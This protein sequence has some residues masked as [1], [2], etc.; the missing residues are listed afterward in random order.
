MVDEKDL[1]AKVMGIEDYR[2]QNLPMPNG[3]KIPKR[4]RRSSSGG[5]CRDC[6]HDTLVGHEDGHGMW[7]YTCTYCVTHQNQNNVPCPR[8][9]CKAHERIGGTVSSLSEKKVDEITSNPFR[10][11]VMTFRCLRCSQ[12]WFN[13]EYEQYLLTKVVKSVSNSSPLYKP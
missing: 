2:K 11:E 8:C 7:H 4:A 3:I 1:Y 5:H 13:P 6:G 12:E 10:P 9:G